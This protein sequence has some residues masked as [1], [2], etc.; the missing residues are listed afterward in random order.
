MFA[1][2]GRDSAEQ[3]SPEIFAERVSFTQGIKRVGTDENR[4]RGHAATRRVAVY[5]ERFSRFKGRL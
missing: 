1:V 3:V 5:L 4:P 2:R